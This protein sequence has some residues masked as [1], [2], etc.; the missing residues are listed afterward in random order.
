[1]ANT[2]SKGYDVAISSLNYGS[3]KLQRGDTDGNPSATPPQKP[4]YEGAEFNEPVCMMEAQTP[5]GQGCTL[6]IPAFVQDLQRDL[7][8]L[9]FL[10]IKGNADGTIKNDTEGDN[11][12][13]KFGRTTEWAVKE[14]QIYASM[15][16]V[17]RLNVE[18]LKELS[19]GSGE[20]AWEVARLGQVPT[21]VTLPEGVT[22]HPVSFYVATLDQVVNGLRYTGPISGELNAETR[23]A[24]K[25]WIKERYRCPVVIEAWKV[26]SANSIDRLSPIDKGINIWQHDSITDNARIRMFSRDF[27]KKYNYESCDKNPNEYHM[28]GLWFPLSGFG[29]PYSEPKFKSTWKSAEIMPE[30][31]IGG[32]NT[33]ETLKNNIESSRTN[34][35][36]VVRAVAERECFGFFDVPNAYDRAL[37]SWGPC[38]W[39]LGLSSPAGRYTNGELSAFLSYFLESDKEAYME[40]IGSFGLLPAAKWNGNGNNQVVNSQGKFTG[41]LRCHSESTATPDSDAL[42]PADLTTNLPSLPLIDR[43]YTEAHYYKSWHWFFRWTMAGRTNKGIQKAAWN[44]ARMRIKAIRNSSHHINTTNSQGVAV[45]FTAKLGDMITSVRG[46]AIVFRWHVWMPAHVFGVEATA[47]PHLRNQI[48]AAIKA[49]SLDWTLPPNQW[50]QQHEDELYNKI[51]EKAAS[52]NNTHNIVHD[53]PGTQRSF[54]ELKDELG[55]LSNVRNSFSLDETGI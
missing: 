41:W 25:F 52:L 23:S 43:T 7:R 50:T 13:G 35:F 26:A 29:G 19:P 37:M 18:R 8:E 36:K 34:T 15:S 5:Q 1:M 11:A 10:V 4:R 42:V 12:A 31:T 49:S 22:P 3:L 55:S 28:L 33:V 47:T 51:K 39:T 17:A 16:H 46:N 30:N 32:D 38:H 27:T 48:I 45:N 20:L 14:F 54:W 53:W 24:I 44:M 40:A 6:S 9:G 21:G 2:T